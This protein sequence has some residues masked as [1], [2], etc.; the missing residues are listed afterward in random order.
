MHNFIFDESILELQRLANTYTTNVNR[1]MLLENVTLESVSPALFRSFLSG[2][3]KVFNDIKKT[4][5]DS[6]EEYSKFEQKCKFIKTNK[7]NIILGLKKMDKDTLIVNI[8]RLDD[9]LKVASDLT[10]SLDKFVKNITLDALKNTDVDKYTDIIKELLNDK[11]KLSTKEI[12]KHVGNICS[13]TNKVIDKSSELRKYV[14]TL[15]DI[16]NGLGDSVNDMNDFISSI[17]KNIPM[18]KNMDISSNEHLPD[19]N[20]LVKQVIL[21]LKSIFIVS[22]TIDTVAIAIAMEYVKL[23]ETAKSFKTKEMKKDNVIAEDS[24]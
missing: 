5:K 20:K 15:V 23:F 4:F 17:H 11:K 6:G 24:K 10:E 16:T 21:F 13:V 1:V 18:L 22:K 19:V 7:S 14:I 12:S 2:I 3:E 8:D 9:L